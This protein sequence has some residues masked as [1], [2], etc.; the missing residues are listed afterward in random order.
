MAAPAGAVAP[1]ADQK[2]VKPE[3]QQAP[4]QP[5]EE[6]IIDSDSD[7]DGGERQMSAQEREVEKQMIAEGV[8]IGACQWVAKQF[9][10]LLQEKRGWA[11][12][13]VENARLAGAAAVPPLLC[14]MQ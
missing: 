13:E 14:H 10:K 6:L 7:E 2:A 11:S 3:P 1:A 9:S 12:K 5:A 8:C 4:Q